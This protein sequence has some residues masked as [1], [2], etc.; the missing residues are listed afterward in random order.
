MSRA[1]HRTRPLITLLL[2]CKLGLLCSRYTDYLI[3]NARIWTGSQNGTG[4]IEG[5]VYFD[6]GIFKGVGGLD[7]DAVKLL[8]S[9]D[10]LDIV[11]ARLN[12]HDESYPLSIAGGVTTALILPGSANTIGKFLLPAEHRSGVLTTCKW[13]GFYDKATQDS[14][15]IDNCD[16]SGVSVSTEWHIPSIRGRSMETYGVRYLD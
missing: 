11:H 7:V 14:G 13:A 6:K 3:L 16:A 12:T 4:F 9:Q 10:R 15:A 5:H 1:Q 8:Y 2:S